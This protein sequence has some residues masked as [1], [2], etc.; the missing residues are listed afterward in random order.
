LDFH[1]NSAFIHGKKHALE[2]DRNLDELVV[3]HLDYVTKLLITH[4]VPSE[5][6][7]LSRTAFKDGFISGFNSI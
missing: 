2:G 5:L 4:K 1:F 7:E 3:G 6:I